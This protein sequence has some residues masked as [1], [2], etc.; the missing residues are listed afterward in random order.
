MLLEGFLIVMVFI[1]KAPAQIVF[2][3]ESWLQ[4]VPVEDCAVQKTLIYKY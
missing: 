3:Q 1:G 4:A 2:G